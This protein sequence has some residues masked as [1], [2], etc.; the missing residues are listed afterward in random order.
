VPEPD[1]K[2]EAEHEFPPEIAQ[3]IV[4][5]F[6]GKRVPLPVKLLPPGPKTV[7]RWAMNR[8]GDVHAVSF[9][10]DAIIFKRETKRNGRERDRYGNVYETDQPFPW[11]PRDEDDRLQKIEALLRDLERKLVIHFCRILNQ[12]RCGD[13]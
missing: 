9:N 6:I 7:A 3:P 11:E 1:K 10:D 4:R 8:L 13:G 5:S 12:G 2:E